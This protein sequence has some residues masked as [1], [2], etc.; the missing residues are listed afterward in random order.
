MT[1]LTCCSWVVTHW[2]SSLVT[3]S[4]LHSSEVMSSQL[5]STTTRHSC[6]CTSAHSSLV[7]ASYLSFSFCLQSCLQFIFFFL[8]RLTF[9]LVDGGALFPDDVPAQLLLLGLAFLLQLGLVHHL[10]L[11]LLDDAALLIVKLDTL[12]VSVGGAHLTNN[13]SFPKHSSAKCARRTKSAS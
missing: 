4:S 12:L 8:P 7:T 2:F 3:V 1:S 6:S 13:L 5:G 9:L 11:L 10:T